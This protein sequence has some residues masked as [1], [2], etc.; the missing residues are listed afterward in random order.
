MT[1]PKA[2]RAIATHAIRANTLLIVVVDADDFSVKDRRYHLQS[3]VR[4]AANDSVA[5]LV[6]KRHVET[7][8]R[9]ALGQ[10]VNELDDYKNPE[11]SKAEVRAAAKQIYGLA[12]G[13]IPVDS[14]SIPS[15]LDAI[16]E[17]RKIG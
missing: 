11:P 7:W 6:P 8:I 1:R 15:L 4:L 12:R 13:K 16:F 3:D 5:I 2:S 10:R 17:W 9:A 14:V